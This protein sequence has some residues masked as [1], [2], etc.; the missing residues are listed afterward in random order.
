MNST[1]KNQAHILRELIDS[2]VDVG[3]I[4]GE[5]Q[6]IDSVASALGL[7]LVLQASGKKVQIVSK[8]DPEVM[9]SNLFG[10]NKIAKSFEGN[11]KIL[12]ISVPYRDGEIEKVS[13]N[14]EGTRL[15][16]NLFAE[17]SG[18]SFSEKDIN[19]IRKGSSPSVVITIGVSNEEELASFVDPSQVRTIH[20]DKNPLNLMQGDAILI[21]PAFSSISEIVAEFIREVSLP[22]DPDG[23][24]NLMD[25][26]TFA[27][28]NFTHPQTSAFAFEAAGFLLQNGA[29][30][31]EKG[32]ENM[33]NRDGGNIKQV[34]QNQGRRDDRSRN[35]PGIDQFLNNRQQRGQRPNPQPANQPRFDRQEEKVKFDKIRQD[36]ENLSEND[37]QNKQNVFQN[38]AP[39][40]FKRPPS[41]PREMNAQELPDELSDSA[42]IEGS[43]PEDIPDDW[44][45]P[46]V[47]KGSK[48]GN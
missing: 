44:F 3:I 48:K 35:F 37:D 28:R 1:V 39:Q 19:Y 2:T 23:F 33:Q 6:N 14:I 40:P 38:Q 29:K 26:I 13:Y 5:N 4:L 8:K 18:I 31:S 15:N 30:R 10:V 36:I 27:T 47:F 24:Q 20:I 21:D 17:E 9:V 32:F 42:F 22:Y 43:L 46:K 16:V 34:I 41:T 11:T 7:Y 25:G 12:T 45:L